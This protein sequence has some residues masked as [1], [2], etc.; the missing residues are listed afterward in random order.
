M[1]VHETHLHVRKRGGDVAKIS[2]LSCLK[3]NE[4]FTNR[5][6]WISYKPF[7]FQEFARFLTGFSK[8]LSLKAEMH[9]VF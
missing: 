3:K 8:W 1:S 2:F 9:K 4:L 5:S 6:I 7:G